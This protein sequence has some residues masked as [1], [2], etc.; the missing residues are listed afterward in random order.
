MCGTL[1]FSMLNN[2]GVF[3]ATTNNEGTK[4]ECPS[5]KFLNPCDIAR[6]KVQKGVD[7]S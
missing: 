3:I 6:R 7:G 4:F 5:G 1:F 2:R